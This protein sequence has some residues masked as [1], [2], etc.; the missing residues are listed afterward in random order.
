MKKTREQMAA[1]EQ[2]RDPIFLLQV[3]RMIVTD[4]WRVEWCETCGAPCLSEAPHDCGD[5][6]A[7]VDF[8]VD[9]DMAQI[10]WRT[11]AVYLTREEADARGVEIAHRFPLGWRVYCVPAEGQLRT[12]LL[13][14]D[15]YAE[16]VADMELA[17]GEVNATW[18][19]I[20]SKSRGVL[21]G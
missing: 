21:R 12:L 17:L 7:A 18:L 16:A 8:L 20:A 4:R 1:E 13:G 15:G 3:G 10:V 9:L 14:I 11:V 2:T 5:T 19:R 6:K